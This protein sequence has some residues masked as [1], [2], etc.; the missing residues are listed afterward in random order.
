MAQHVLKPLREWG[1]DGVIAH[2]LD[3]KV[4][5]E[6]GELRV[7]LVNTTS[8]LSEL[9]HPLV[10][11][12]HGAVGRMAAAYFMDRGFTNFGF[13]GSAHAGFSREREAG[14][15]EALAARGYS[16]TACYAEYL[17]RPSADVSW[18]NVDACVRAWLN[19]LSKPVAILSSNDVPA[20]ELADICRQ[21]KLDVPNQVALLGV[22]NDELECN[23]ATPPLSSI[24]LPA[25]Q[26]GYEAAE[27][28]ER[29][30]A[31][32]PL[33]QQR[34]HLAPIRVVSRFSTDTLAVEDPDLRVALSYIRS[35]AHLEISVES[36]HEH[37]AVSRRL[38]ERKFRERLGRTVL[39]EIRRTRIELAKQLLTE[40]DLPM[41]AVAKRAG[42]SGA[43]RLAVVFRQE[44]T[45]TPSEFRESVRRHNSLSHN[46]T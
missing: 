46:D 12:D 6:L 19:E 31:G 2:L 7:P 17:P 40:T 24:V 43:R 27:Q 35:H 18:V 13:F 5:E 42:F 44:E 14:F 9:N 28:L 41:P 29:L 1:P 16:A 3:R 34:T 20:R 11:A 30:M 37:A 10:E 36:V 32:E 26:I 38:L 23:L 33:R 39:N 8:T 15:R 21:L 45:L 25:Q 4:A 22:D